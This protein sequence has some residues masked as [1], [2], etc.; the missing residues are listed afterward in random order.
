M[1][2]WFRKGLVGSLTGAVKK[3]PKW[4]E[5]KGTGRLNWTCNPIQNLLLRP[6]NKL[7]GVMGREAQEIL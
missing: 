1:R 3:V 7:L 2:A 4:R 5:S 6:S